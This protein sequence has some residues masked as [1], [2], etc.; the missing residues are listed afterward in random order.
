MISL[1]PWASIK[2][3]IAFIAMKDQ[4]I[5]SLLQGAA[6]ALSEAPSSWVNSAL[7]PGRAN[8]ILLQWKA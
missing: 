3:S 1:L 6:E 5:P 2:H 7:N 4:S 8:C